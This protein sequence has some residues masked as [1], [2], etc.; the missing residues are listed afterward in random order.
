MKAISIHAY[1]SM[2]GKEKQVVVEIKKGIKQW[3]P[4]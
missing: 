4:A 1:Y 2:G 3:V